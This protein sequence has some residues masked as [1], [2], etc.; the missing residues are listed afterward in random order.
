MYAI[1]IIIYTI[2][3]YYFTFYISE[4]KINFENEIDFYNNKE[5][6]PKKVRFEDTEIKLKVR[7]QESTMDIEKYNPNR[8]MTISIK[9]LKQL[10]R[11]ELD[12]LIV[13]GPC[14]T[15]TACRILKTVNKVICK[16]KYSRIKAEQVLKIKK[17][18]EKDGNL[19]SEA[20]KCK[21]Q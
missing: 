1:I 10:A 13:T 7:L 14:H 15:T 19:E 8:N 6:V 3:I 16:K 4:R 9:P 11:E 2:L 18:I 12:K 21:V 17:Y 5:N 20:N